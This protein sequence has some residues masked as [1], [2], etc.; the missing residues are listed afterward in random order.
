MGLLIKNGASLPGRYRGGLEKKVFK[1]ILDFVKQPGVPEYV[2]YPEVLPP[3]LAEPGHF[4]G[5]SHGKVHFGYFETIVVRAEIG[6][7]FMAEA[8]FVG[9]CQEK[10]KGLF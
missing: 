9:V 4:A 7:P 1:L 10:A 5:P 2:R 6:Q 3:A 8:A